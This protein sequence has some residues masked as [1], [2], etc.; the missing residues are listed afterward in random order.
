M[1]SKIPTA[2]AALSLCLSLS[3]PAFANEAEATAEADLTDRMKL[4]ETEQKDGGGTLYWS[5]GV[6]L[7][8]LR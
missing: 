5:Y 6:E 1:K 8:E 2:F 3:N 7:R 4:C